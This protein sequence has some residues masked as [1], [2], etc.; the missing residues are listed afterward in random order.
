MASHS[1]YSTT[2]LIGINDNSCDIEDRDNLPLLLHNNHH[3]KRILKE[4]STSRSWQYRCFSSDSDG[5]NFRLIL[6][7]IWGVMCM[8]IKS[9]KCHYYIVLYALYKVQTHQIFR[10]ITFNFI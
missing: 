10:Y 4:Y 3:N 9:D 1:I 6:C 5:R 2:G 7:F 8:V